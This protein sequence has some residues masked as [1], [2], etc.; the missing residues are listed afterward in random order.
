MDICRDVV[1]LFSS[2]LSEEGK[3][4]GVHRIFQTEKVTWT[5]L[6]FMVIWVG[7]LCEGQPLVGCGCPVQPHRESSGEETPVG[8]SCVTEHLENN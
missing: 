8:W 5:I 4:L 2:V 6:K 1:S 7:S 3:V